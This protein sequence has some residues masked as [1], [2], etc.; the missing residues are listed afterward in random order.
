M[1]LL[2]CLDEKVL[3]GFTRQK[4]KLSF[5]SIWLFICVGLVQSGRE[6]MMLA[7]SS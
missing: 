1:Q 2:E 3:C 7:L 6:K 5:P 4:Y